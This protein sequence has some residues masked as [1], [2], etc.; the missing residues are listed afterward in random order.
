MNPLVGVLLRFRQESVALMAHV[1]SMFHQVRVYPKDIDVLRFLWFPNGDL[2]KE[3]E[4]YQ[5]LVQLFG[6]VW[7]PCCASFA[8]KKTAVDNMDRYDYEITETVERN[9]YVDDMLKSMKD[10]ESAI[11]LYTEVTKLL[12]CEGFHL[13]KWTSNKRDV[14]NAIPDCELSKE[15]KSIDFEKDTLPTERAW[16]CNGI[17][18]KINFNTIPASRISQQQDKEY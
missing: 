8:L 17:P 7:S 13:T 15:L 18:S 14:L 11:K 12:S 1:E 3:P 6:G 5:M 9:F 16:V 4:E 2:D 10:T